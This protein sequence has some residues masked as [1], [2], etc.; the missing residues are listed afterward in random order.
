MERNIKPSRQIL[1]LVVTEQCNLACSYCF[2]ENKKSGTKL[3]LKTAQDRIEEAFAN[4]RFD[5]LEIDFFGGEPFMAFAT[6]ANICEW[7]WS[8][9]WP[10]PYICFATTNGTLIH[11][12][13]KEWILRNRK[14]F[15]L[16]LSL[17][18]TEEMHNANRSNSYSR[19]DFALFRDSWPF[20]PVKMTLS[21]E[22]LPHLAEGVIHIH[23]L[24]FSLTCNHAFGIDWK[25]EDGIIF[26][27]QIKQLIEF[28]LEH[29]A[30]MPCDLAS[31]PIHEI[32]TRPRN[33]NY[34]GAG[35]SLTCCDENGEP[36]PC[37]TF[38]PMT[39]GEQIN[40]AQMFEVLSGEENATPEECS[41]CCLLPVCQTCYGLNFR[42]FGSPFARD[43]EHCMFSR[44]RAKAMAY[45]VS[46]MMTDTIKEYAYMRDKSDLQ[47]YRL[48]KA[49]QMI[50]ETVNI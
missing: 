28:Y 30:I 7:L 45:F 46:M 25:P 9:K 32:F 41:S 37:Q 13:I 19:I 8:Q 20:Q 43:P 40:Q 27:E 39:L 22:A 50:N 36:Y 15:V 44:I 2:E 31:M 34:C 12:K 42:K 49:A 11:G 1:K 5:E 4:P 47:L 21:R 29:P 35:K 3:S 48:I 26:A 38:L 33:K 16:G 10:K 14:G 23:G 17:D 18:G 6:I 24:G